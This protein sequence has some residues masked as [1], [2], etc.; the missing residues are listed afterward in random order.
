[1]SGSNNATAQLTNRSK[2]ARFRR[3]PR[4][5]RI[6]QRDGAADESI[7]RSI[8][9]SASNAKPV[10]DPAKT[11]AG[12][13][14][15]KQ[16]RQYRSGRIES[17]RIESNRKA[18]D[19]SKDQPKCKDQEDKGAESC[20][21]GDLGPFVAVDGVEEED[22]GLLGGREAVLAEVRAELVGPAKAAALAAAPKP[23]ALCDFLP[24]SFAVLL[25]VLRQKLVFARAP[26]PLL[27][28]GD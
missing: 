10:F 6:E 7:D 26:R 27:R 3:D 14:D 25:H 12:G 13:A 23:R 22:G 21:G 20:L 8:D 5:E 15:P 28:D 1:M 2:S 16:A 4:N 24:V 11:P 9:R 18:A 19:Q 17:N